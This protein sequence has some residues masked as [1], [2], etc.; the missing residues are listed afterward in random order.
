MVGDKDTDGLTP[1]RHTTSL[2]TTVTSADGVAYLLPVDPTLGKDGLRS[3][4][5]MARRLARV[6]MR[7]AWLIAVSAEANC[8]HSSH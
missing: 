6:A 1:S 3:S 5:A 2:G 7:G 4:S 8:A